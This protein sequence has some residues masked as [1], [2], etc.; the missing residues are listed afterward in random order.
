MTWRVRESS[1]A[2]TRLAPTW[3][4]IVPGTVPGA[5]AI[6]FELDWLGSHRTSYGTPGKYPTLST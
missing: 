2:S 6:S 4:C 5:G 1:V 3:L